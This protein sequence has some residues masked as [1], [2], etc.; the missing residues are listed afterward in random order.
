M[1]LPLPLTRTQVLQH[2]F[3][4]SIDWR[5]LEAKDV[6]VP[7]R[8]EIR[9]PLDTS[10]FDSYPSEDYARW[11]AYNEPGLEPTWSKE[12]GELTGLTG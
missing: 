4:R 5:K 9:D 11:D 3:F 1:T 10:N 8:P 12:F 6:R 2:D 7:Y